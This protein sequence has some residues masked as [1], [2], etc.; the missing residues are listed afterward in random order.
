MADQENLTNQMETLQSAETSDATE[1]VIKSYFERG[2]PEESAVDLETV[3]LFLTEE[4]QSE[5]V[6]NPPPDF[7]VVGLLGKMQV[8]DPLS[9]LAKEKNQELQN[10]INLNPQIRLF[11]QVLWCRGCHIILEDAACS[12]EDLEISRKQWSENTR[13]VYLLVTRSPGYM[14]DLKLFFQAED[15]TQAQRVI[16]A[17]LMVEVYKT[18]IHTAAKQIKERES[19]APIEFNVKAM[20]SEGLAKLRHVGA[21]AVRKVLNSELKY[22]RDNIASPSNH[23]QQLVKNSF[24]RSQLLE[25]YVVGNFSSLEKNSKYPETLNVTEE[26]QF[27]N[28]GLTHIEDTAYEFFLDAESLRVGLLNESKVKEFKGTLVDVALLTLKQEETLQNKWEMCFPGNIIAENKVIM[29]H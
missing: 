11:G 29:T 19:I 12:M 8:D 13:K 14:R 9:E 6:K 5:F 3:Y 2:D 28:R 21:W 17:E 15:L 4:E 27:R 26:R 1:R 22:V 23:T 24:A 7:D 25:E 16:G 10:L 20:A 18:N